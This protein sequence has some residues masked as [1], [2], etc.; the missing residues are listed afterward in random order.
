MSWCDIAIAD[1]NTLLGYPE[2]RAGVPSATVVPSLLR[3]VGRKK[4]YE[5][6]LTGEYI[7]PA[8][9]SAIGL[10][11]RV[12]P[13]GTSLEAARAMA[14][15]IAKHHPDAIGLTKEIIHA[16]TDMSYEQGIVYAKEV[17]IISRLRRD[18]Q[19]E[20]AAGGDHS[21]NGAG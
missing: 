1:D 5:L 16:A 13:A 17:R 3:L 6:L 4:M 21:A 19:V 2:V 11:S 12:V 15:T 18:F 14:A 7:A 20:V 10:V 9:A 8:E